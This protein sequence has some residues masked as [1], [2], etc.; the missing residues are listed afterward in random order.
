MLKRFFAT[1]FGAS[2]KKNETV[3]E[4]A[5]AST[6]ETST[7]K[8]D[9]VTED[10]PRNK[11]LQNIHNAVCH[12]DRYDILSEKSF[13]DL[14]ELIPAFIAEYGDL[15]LDE[16]CWNWHSYCDEVSCDCYWEPSPVFGHMDVIVKEFVTK[17][18]AGETPDVE[19]YTLRYKL[20]YDLKKAF[21]DRDICRFDELLSAGADIN[22]EYVSSYGTITTLWDEVDRARPERMYDYFMTRDDCPQVVTRK[23]ELELIASR[24]K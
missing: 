13:V 22:Y 16:K 15:S 9:E 3:H 17:L 7:K 8:K 2:S 24:K 14:A 10:D 1:L 11:V 23:K 18:C 12:K 20:Q 21:D 6:Q 19:E 5:V 4:E